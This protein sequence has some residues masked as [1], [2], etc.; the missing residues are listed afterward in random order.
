MIDATCTLKILKMHEGISKKGMTFVK[1]TGYI[2]NKIRGGTYISVF[3]YGED[4]QSWVMNYKANDFIKVSGNITA[5]PYVSQ[6]DISKL[7]VSLSIFARE[8]ELISVAPESGSLKEAVT[9]VEKAGT[10]LERNSKVQKPMEDI[11][12]DDNDIPF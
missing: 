11:Y 7:Y 10:L 3:F 12:E 2:P 5:Q 8:Y 1:V 6:K 4:G 9:N